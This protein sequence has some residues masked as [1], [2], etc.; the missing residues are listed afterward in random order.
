MPPRQ[1]RQRN[2]RAPADRN[3][4]ARLMRVNRDLRRTQIDERRNRYREAAEQRAAP[5]LPRIRDASD[6]A[7]RVDISPALD[8]TVRTAVFTPNARVFHDTVQYF[9]DLEPLVNRVI[10]GEFNSHDGGLKM[11]L[12]VT[13]VIFQLG[14][15]REPYPTDILSSNVTVENAAEIRGQYNAVTADI[16]TQ[17]SD[18]CM[19]GSNWVIERV[20]NAVL[21]I[22][23]F[24]RNEQV[25]GHG[26]RLLPGGGSFM[27]LPTWI[28]NKHACV[29]IDNSDERCFLYA[30]AAAWADKNGVLPDKNKERSKQYEQ[31]FTKF[32]TENMVF[33]FVL[34]QSD[35]TAKCN[36]T[37][38]ERQNKE[39][40]MNIKVLVADPEDKRFTIAY[41]SHNDDPT[42]WNI[43]L[44]LFGN[45]GYE[46][47]HYCYVHRVN[48]LLNRAE[49]TS[50]NNKVHCMN[51]LRGFYSPSALDK[52]RNNFMCARNPQCKTVF[53]YGDK[54]Y[55]TFTK[56]SARTKSE[57]IVYADFECILVKVND[58]DNERRT[59]THVPCG[60]TTALICTYNRDLSIY[61]WPYRA[62]NGS[63]TSDVGDRF[64]QRLDEY[65]AI[66]KQ[67]DLDFN[68]EMELSED[69]ED[70]YSK[71]TKCYLCDGPFQDF[72]IRGWD[73]KNINVNLRKVKDHDHRK[74]GRNY[75]GAAHSWC[76][77][78]LRGMF[79]KRAWSKGEEENDDPNAMEMDED[80]DGAPSDDESDSVSKSEYNHRVPVVFHN[81]KGYDSH[82]IITSLSKRNVQK[83]I[84]CIPQPGEKFLSLSFNGYQ[85]IDSNAFLQSSLD[86]LS[87]LLSKNG[88]DL[89]KLIHTR[90][91]F[92][93]VISPRLNL[94]PNEELF[95]MIAKKGTYPYDYMDSFARFEETKLPEKSAFYSKLNESHIT[96]DDYEHALRVFDR[97]EL[98]N[99]GQY[100]DVY[101]M[102]DV[103]LL[104]DV[105]E[106]FRDTTFSDIGLDP[107]RF[108]SLPGL[109]KESNLRKHPNIIDC[110]GIERPF[111]VKLF[112]EKQGDMHLFCKN[113]IRGGIS[114]ISGRLLK[115]NDMYQIVYVD[116][117]NLY[118][119]AMSQWIPTGDYR[120]WNEWECQ[121]ATHAR[122]LSLTDDGD[123]GYLFE[124][125]L[126]IPPEIHDKLRDYPIAPTRECVRPQDLSPYSR[127]QVKRSDRHADFKTEKLLCTLRDKVAYTCHF[128]N[129][130]LYIQLGAVI[131]KV[132]RVLEFTQKLW[133]KGFIDYHSQKRAAATSDFVKNY[134]KLVANSTYGKFLQNDAKHQSIE[135]VTDRHRQLK[136]ARDPF[137]AGYQEVNPECLLVERTKKE[138]K[139]D[140]PNIVGVCILEM[141][142]LRMY[143][144]YYNTMKPVFGDR[145]RLGMTDTDS[146]IMEIRTSDWRSE[147]AASGLLGEFDFS[148]Y[149]KDHPY[150]SPVNKKVVGKFKDEL[151]GVLPLGFVG[152]RSKMYSIKLPD[153]HEDIK[154][155]KGV[156]AYVV[157]KGLTY[158]DYYNCLTNPLF[159][160]PVRKVL[161]FSSHNQTIHTESITKTTL[162]AADT[163]LYVF[164]DGILTA[165][166]G[167]Y[168]LP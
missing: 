129:L 140:K 139:L 9:D 16:M 86:K 96:D 49:T 75:R 126:H 54:A 111:E 5:A 103:L 45:D 80:D 59:Q 68:H 26:V 90:R 72:M 101:L 64:L 41:D 66:M 138:I 76:N 17:I 153:G 109:G 159:Q 141:S 116:A 39:L 156:K 22:S 56:Y 102:L 47:T 60:F 99:L 118:G 160:P 50:R 29:N 95:A 143:D 124:V 117:N 151:N 24:N 53:P 110:N 115:G 114:L 161:G 36:M 79:R 30:M 2:V 125:D 42:A 58:P 87:Q 81:L 4:R 142:K 51:C 20:E 46:Q 122:I 93:N 163:K 128:R 155:A 3:E 67:H 35:M 83:D 52:H 92:E 112:E 43:I 37:A 21:R 61:D 40:N 104:T 136:L 23:E 119:W 97:F 27:P 12:E 98:D 164:D 74:P 85:F 121:I 77:L 69:D 84:Y 166:F 149:P 154:K 73:E 165:P 48:A 150:Y 137:Y 19:N 13:F 1:Q 108:V 120:W 147:I 162:S 123:K 157:K 152:L 131:K 31:Y 106:S 57:W 65:M 78:Q 135:I 6:N 132:H 38:F 144:F 11:S 113:A 91:G 14:T 133:I 44:L 89:S 127:A 107:A 168:K 71:A 105:F 25:S 10:R 94:M 145:M 63:S 82:I 167:Y 34:R 70:N 62:P 8:H 100:H 15:A 7:F 55:Y 146:L 158:E 32:N 33:P 88:D 148:D 134:H 28:K 130:K 18:F